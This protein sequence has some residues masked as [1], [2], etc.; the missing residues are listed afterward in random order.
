MDNQKNLKMLEKNWK[1]SWC[2]VSKYFSEIPL[3][4][5][6]KKSTQFKKRKKKT[7]NAVKLKKNLL[8]ILFNIDSNEPIQLKWIYIK[9]KLVTDEKK[10]SENSWEYLLHR[11][12]G[13]VKN[14][15][16]LWIGAKYS[17]EIPIEK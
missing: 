9:N 15:D 14:D 10:K 8:E 6:N 13:I 17:K 16:Y 7:I 5:S 12:S 11:F 3:L 2:S 4:C 1:N